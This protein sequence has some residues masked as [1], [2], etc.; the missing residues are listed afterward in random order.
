VTRLAFSADGRW[1][2]STDTIGGMRV[3]PVPDFSHPPFHTLPYDALMRKLYTLTNVRV[4]RDDSSPDG[5]K[6]EIGPFPGWELVPE[7]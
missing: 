3:W 5:W 7:W 2:A 4:V 6:R 1:L